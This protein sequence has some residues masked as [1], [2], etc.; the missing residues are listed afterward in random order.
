VLV[1][2]LVDGKITYVHR[3]LWPALVRLAR[4]FDAARLARVWD[5]HTE[6]GAH[7][8][9]REPFPRWVPPE[10]MKEAGALTEAAAEKVLAPWPALAGGPSAK[11][12]AKK[13]GRRQSPR[14]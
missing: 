9:M 1:C 8:A 13:A 6:S 5:E 4:R 10:V 3:R 12:P 11:G 2:K 7:R 14:A